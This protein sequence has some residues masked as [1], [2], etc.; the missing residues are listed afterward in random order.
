MLQFNVYCPGIRSSQYVPHRLS[1]ASQPSVHF[2]RLHS[3]AQFPAPWLLSSW[4]RRRIDCGN[5]PQKVVHAFSV[6]SHASS[7]CLIGSAYCSSS[8]SGSGGTSPL[9]THD[10]STVDSGRRMMTMAAAWCV[11]MNHGG[12]HLAPRR[13]SASRGILGSSRSCSTPCVPS[14]RRRHLS[15]SREAARAAQAGGDRPRASR[16]PW[17][18]AR[19]SGRR[20]AEAS[21]GPSTARAGVYG[22]VG[23]LCPQAGSATCG[24]KAT[25]P[26]CDHGIGLAPEDQERIFQRF[27]R[28][29]SARH[30]GGFGLGLWITRQVVEAMGGSI[31]VDSQLGHGSTFTVELPR[32]GAGGA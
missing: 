13:A 26:F 22:D 3:A 21:S 24:P 14:R 12:A 32:A 19:G 27:E 17:L 9:W 4:H 16:W 10:A 7:H 11:R 15:R 25:R 5:E 6:A 23:R 20:G 29:V 30:Y 28:A 8:M 31:R 18:P 1:N 2:R